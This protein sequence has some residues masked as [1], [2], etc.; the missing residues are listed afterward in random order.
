MVLLGKVEIIDKEEEHSVVVIIYTVMNGGCVYVCVRVFCNGDFGLMVY[1]Y[2]RHGF[3]RLYCFY[4]DMGRCILVKGLYK[5][6][7]D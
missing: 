2:H 1:G 4:S 5:Y 3:C 6:K 7:T